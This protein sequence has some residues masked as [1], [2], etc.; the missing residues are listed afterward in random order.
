MDALFSQSVLVNPQDSMNVGEASCLKFNPEKNWVEFMQKE[1]E[2]LNYLPIVVVCNLDFFLA[3]SHDNVLDELFDSV[4]KVSSD[5]KFIAFEE[6][7]SG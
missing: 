2:V 3:R 5:E 4:V 1:D 6:L 7:K